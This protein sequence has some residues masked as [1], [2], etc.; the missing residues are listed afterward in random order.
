M[1]RSIRSSC[2]F[3]E[4]EVL[5]PPRRACADN[6]QR[7]STA[8]DAMRCRQPRTLYSQG[9]HRKSWL[10]EDGRVLEPML[11]LKL[12]TSATKGFLLDESGNL[13]LNYC[14]FG[15]LAGQFL[16]PNLIEAFISSL[17]VVPAKWR[18][19]WFHCSCAFQLMHVRGS[20]SLEGG[21]LDVLW[22]INIY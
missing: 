18:W 6:R 21:A 19:W 17:E 11:C 8:I 13:P 4:D 20:W 2:I 3:R 1:D 7:S 5:W 10:R 15:S 16:S 22:S 14:F 12:Q 9:L